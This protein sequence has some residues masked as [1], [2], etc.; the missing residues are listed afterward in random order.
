MSE[1]HGLRALQVR[2][3]RQDRVAGCI[4]ARHEDLL[5][6]VGA[7]RDLPTFAAEPEAEI[8][9]NLVVAAA[10]GV[11]LGASRSRELGHPSFHCGVDVLIRRGELEAAVTQ[12]PI[13]RIESAED[14]CDL[15]VAQQPDASEH[16]HVRA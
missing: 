2:V 1:Q 14:R 16:A 11:E 12:L 9:G 10:S 4:G 15:R 6:R 5:Q 7:A 13:H 8:G 3:A